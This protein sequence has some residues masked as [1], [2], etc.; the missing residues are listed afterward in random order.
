MSETA[1]MVITGERDRLGR[2]P[3]T[4]FW[5]SQGAAGTPVYRDGVV[6]GRRRAQCFR[7]VP[8]DYLK[9]GAQLVEDEA[10]AKA[11]AWGES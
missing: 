9:R 3:F 2:A 8:E 5:L 6:V 1:Y 4:L 10:T 7:A 11:R